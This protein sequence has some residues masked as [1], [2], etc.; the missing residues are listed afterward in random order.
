M[1]SPRFK[2]PLWL[3]SRKLLA[4]WGYKAYFSAGRSNSRGVAILFKNNFEFKV[5]KI[6]KDTDGNYISVHV[7]MKNDDFLFVNIYGPNRDQ[8][9]F[10][11]ELLKK[12]QKT[13]IS[14]IITAGDWNM[15]LDT[16]R[17]YH[18][19]RRITVQKQEKLW[20]L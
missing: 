17:D 5:K 11:N 10:Y 20:N 1:F 3:R 2:Y 6:Y 14:N 19:I 13:G 8:P 7:S 18:N 4:E 16:S 9:D 12:I 15:V